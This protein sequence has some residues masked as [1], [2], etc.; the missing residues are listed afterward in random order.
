MQRPSR[1][2]EGSSG[3]R[4]R[5]RPYSALPA[6][7]RTRTPRNPPQ[8]AMA[9]SSRECPSGLRSATNT[10]TATRRPCQHPSNTSPEAPSPAGRW[11]GGKRGKRVVQMQASEGPGEAH[12]SPSPPFVECACMSV[13]LEPNP[14]PVPPTQL[15]PHVQVLHFHGW[16]LAGRQRAARRVAGQAAAEER[17]SPQRSR[18]S[19]QRWV[20]PRNRAAAGATCNRLPRL[21]GGPTNSLPD[22]HALWAS[23][24][25]IHA[26]LGVSRSA[27]GTR[28][29]VLLAAILA[30]N[31]LIGLPPALLFRFAPTSSTPA[32][33]RRAAQP[34][35]PRCCSWR[36]GSFPGLV[37]GPARRAGR[38]GG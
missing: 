4:A 26:S 38:A 31:L 28:A 21:A 33:E 18:G 10:L 19:Q 12:R 32:W 17:G 3:L 27:A 6:Q 37:G 16:Q 34:A 5:S 7:P 14:P 36:R 25:L 2:R 23:S 1:R 20:Q 22:W 35:L 9:I 11:D 15:A 13:M 8:K 24:C 30:P 29:T